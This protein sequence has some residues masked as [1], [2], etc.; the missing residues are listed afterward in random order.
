MKTKIPRTY[1]NKAF[2]Y[3]Y[4]SH[5]NKHVLALCAF[6]FFSAFGFS[7]TKVP[8]IYLFYKGDTLNG[9]DMNA[10]YSAMLKYHDRVNLSPDEKEM[11][12][13]VREEAFVRS[14]YNQ[15]SPVFFDN[16]IAEMATPIDKIAHA[17]KFTLN[18]HNS[19]LR[20]AAKQPPAICA[21]GCDNLDWE[22]SANNHLNNWVGSMGYTTPATVVL[23]QNLA[24][25]SSA[26]NGG[27]AP[28]NAPKK[29]VGAG[30]G[31]GN[32]SGP[33]D[34]TIDNKCTGVTVVSTG[35]DPYSCAPCT[36][37]V[38]TGT[39]GFSCRLGDSHVNMGRTYGGNPQCGWGDDPNTGTGNE[40]GAEWVQYSLTVDASNVLLTYN[41]Q[42]IIQDGLHNP[43]SDQ[44]FF[45]AGALDKNG[46]D[47]A[48]ASYIQE[49]TAGVPP[50][51]YKLSNKANASGNVY[52][53][54]WQSNTFDLTAYMNTT[55]TLYF[56]TGGCVPGGHF[57]YGYIDGH[58]GPKVLAT[59]GPTVCAGSNITVDAPPLPTGTTYSW[60][61]PGIVGSN[62]GATIVVNKGGNY[63]VT[64][65]L[66]APNNTCP[67]SVTANVAFYPSPTMTGTTTN[68]LC[69]GGTG[70][71]LATPSGGTG[72]FA[73]TWSP[74]PTGGQSTNTA[75]GLAC[76]TTYTCTVTDANN[77]PVTKSYP[78][79]CPT[80]LAAAPTQ[81][82]INCSGL[83]TG[84][85]KPVVSGGTGT[86]TYSW[87]GPGAGFTGTG[88]GTAT[89]STLCAGT[90]SVT[91]TDANSCPLT[92]PSFTITQN[93]ALTVASTATTA[94]GCGVSTGMDSV[95]TGGG[96][97]NGVAPFYTF[98]W[99]GPGAVGFTG[100]GQGTP[101]VTN[102]GV[103]TYTCTV[104]DSKGCTQNSVVTINTANGPVL[105]G[106]STNVP[107]LTCNNACI[108]KAG[109][110]V[111]GG[112]AP[113]TYAWTNTASTVDSAF[114]LCAGTY[115][116]SV[117][118]KNSCKSSQSF[119]ITQPTP[120]TM[121]APTVAS[122]T[123]GGSNG[124]IAISP[125]G[126]NPAYT[127]TWSGPVGAFTG[128]GQGT[129]NV[130]ALTSGTYTVVVA[131]NSG[132][133]KTFT[134]AVSN[135]GGPS[136]AASAITNPNCFASC[137]G[138]IVNNA[139]GGAAPLTYSWSGPGGGFTGSGQ[140]TATA[141]ALCAGLYTC[142]VTDNNLCQ[143]S[144]VDSVKTPPAVIVVSSVQTNISCNSG[145]CNGYA[146][147]FVSGGNPSYVYSWNQGATVLGTV[148][149][150]AISLCPGS[151]TCTITDT[152]GCTNPTAQV[153]NITQPSALSSIPT[154]SNITCNGQNNG[155]I[156]LST[157]GGTAG[158]SGYS[159]VWNPAGPTGCCPINLAPGKDTCT[160]T[161][162]LGCTTQ[163]IATITQPSVLSATGAKTNSTCQKPNG[164]ASAA[165]TGGSGLT[166]TYAWS[167][168]GGTAATASNLAPDNYTCTIT[169]SL[170]CQTTVVDTIVNTTLQPIAIITAN[171][172]SDTVCTGTSGGT[173]SVSNPLVGTTYVWM[174]G[175]VTGNSIAINSTTT[176]PY[177]LTATNVCGTATDNKTIYVLSAPINPTVTGGGDKCPGNLDTL[178]SHVLPVDPSTTYLWT[179]APGGT[180]PYI[181]VNAAGVWTVNIQNKCGSASVITT[182]TLYNIAAHF[183]PNIL[184][185][186]APQPVNFIDSS[187]V[188]AISWSWNFGDGSTSVLQN[189]THTFAG[190]GTYTVVETVTDINGCT[191]NYTQTIDIKELP[192]FITPPNVF[193]PNGDGVND[194]WKVRYQGISTF[195]CKIYD[196]WGVFMSEL[197]APG[198]GWDG[199]TSAGL[200]AV[201]GTYYYMLK[202]KGDDGKSYEFT[203]FLMLIRE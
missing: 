37:M 94:T 92:V 39:G 119:T 24:P 3:T 62:T 161:D 181:V 105:T 117:T 14:K 49:I 5:M 169:D 34:A 183:R 55:I 80:S 158:T 148:A 58:C 132:C 134:V 90:Y 100:T 70:S 170:G 73:Y 35:T 11:F 195:D 41:Y 166:Y 1:T 104:K 130:S 23:W 133:S 164:T 193:T 72:A 4:T 97:P 182:V 202:A 138:Q 77:C 66:P 141:S 46:N 19:L 196:R 121:A 187:T 114:N 60:S 82:N 29:Y 188:T 192:S 47:I 17:K 27:P 199:R 142:T 144:Q 15:G 203:G 174:P 109:V 110:S 6:L 25:L 53:S 124:T 22:N 40:A 101:K 91:V 123:C 44:P 102:L 107:A 83:C 135:S 137:I 76:G 75:T 147:V 67:I 186:Y 127:Y 63:T 81:T 45:Q 18:P 31:G 153:F 99:V 59:V 191:A 129:N 197:L 78:I 139:T 128:T 201:P 143:V 95:T 43:T 96:T 2:T 89:A 165:P 64:W 190:V 156:S 56:A 152:K 163:I 26:P 52:Y 86:I 32:F 157:T 69:G 33:M 146:K 28:S 118:D 162:S 184:V 189:P 42:V 21:N 88:Q 30:A 180:L 51:G 126:G 108:G 171:I 112:T 159:Y 48:C 200:M 74:A 168:S 131:D 145:G 173:L 154:V 8:D 98:T 79:T 167:P 185:G 16:T 113:F 61:G 68:P 149:D 178:M 13:K 10:C 20:G 198:A 125:S 57:C 85:A 71:A 175:A 176:T 103:G 116:C 122:A 50:P 7:Q 12:M 194:E 179:P 84:T 120:I 150:T 151:Y 155:S 9:F 177:T 140:G 172:T 115:V 65:T 160:I 111:T 38:F 36:P 54:G 93:P 87:S 106:L 136:P